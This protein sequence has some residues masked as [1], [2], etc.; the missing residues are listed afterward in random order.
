MK[1]PET[2]PKC[3]AVLEGDGLSC[4]EC[5]WTKRERSDFAQPRAA[6][7]HRFD[8]SYEADGLRCR[9]PGNSS[10]RFGGPWFCR[11]H[12]SC[13]DPGEGARLVHESQAYIAEDNEAAHN[14]AVAAGLKKYGM[15]RRPG[16]SVAEHIERMREFCRNGMRELIARN[17]RRA[18]DA[19]VAKDDAR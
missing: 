7:P 12:V 14:A 16:E 2:C 10:R 6:D 9:Y 17:A 11:W 4:A 15:E 18:A 13:V 5:G 1:K 3:H 19:A 8:C